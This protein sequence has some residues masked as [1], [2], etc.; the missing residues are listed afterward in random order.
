MVREPSCD[1]VKSKSCTKQEDFSLSL[2]LR[3]KL[4]HFCDYLYSQPQ[5]LLKS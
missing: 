1:L 4:E 3:A 2:S 5:Q